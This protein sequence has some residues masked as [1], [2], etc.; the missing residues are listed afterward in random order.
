LGARVCDIGSGTGCV[1]FVAALLGA[2]VTLT[3][4]NCV[5][6]LLEQN[7]I[8]FLKEHVT[9]CKNDI[10]VKIY[11]WG[12]AINHLEP[13]FDFILVSDCVLPKLYPIEMLIKVFLFNLLGFL[14]FY[15]LSAYRRLLILLWDPI[16]LLSFRMNIVP[17]H[18]M[19]HDM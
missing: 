1:G 3:D 17:S 4:Q 15:K 12:M 7:R 11:D 6:F 8:S 13:P 10:E 18:S 5:L 14:Y 16:L 19:I 2:K 9:M